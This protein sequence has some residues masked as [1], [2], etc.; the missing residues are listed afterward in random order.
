MKVSPFPNDVLKKLERLR[1]LTGDLL[2]KY[3]FAVG[4][5]NRWMPDAARPLFL[6]KIDAAV[7]EAGALLQSVVG[8][9]AVAYLASQSKRLRTDAQDMYA[10]VHPGES[11]PERA[12]DAI[13]TDVA[14]RLQTAMQKVI[15][16]R[17]SFSR[18]AFIPGEE[19]T[20][21]SPWAQPLHLLT[22][23][24]IFARK[25]VDD[26]FHWRGLQQDREAII[27]AMNVA[28]DIILDQAR[29]G[30]R[31]MQGPEQLVFIKQVQD[32]DATTINKCRAL[33]QLIRDGEM[34]PPAAR[35]PE[36]QNI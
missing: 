2:G 21:S 34:T 17:V 35:K 8:G 36:S 13:M 22:S 15:L 16:P 14:R 33:W 29:W 10:Q 1:S 6:A 18:L 23:M 7:K 32:S 25:D 28:D 5:G 3:S 20:S 12:F 4:D 19:S 27:A 31:V 9:D 30:A 24:A 11:L 26:P